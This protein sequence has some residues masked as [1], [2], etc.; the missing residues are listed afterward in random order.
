[1]NR[2][3]VYLSLITQLTAVVVS[4]NLER[5]TCLNPFWIILRKAYWKTL[6]LF[7]SLES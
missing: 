1:M 7:Y 3:S 2:N 6:S 4:M 5:I